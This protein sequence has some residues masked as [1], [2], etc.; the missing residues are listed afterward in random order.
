MKKMIEK[1]EIKSDEIMDFFVQ[2]VPIA[3]A[4]FMFLASSAYIIYKTVSLKQYRERW[5]DYDE[6]GLS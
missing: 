1:V 5:K 4:L 6:C 2:A 3:I